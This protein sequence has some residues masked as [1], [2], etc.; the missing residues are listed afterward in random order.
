MQSFFYARLAKF[1]QHCAKENFASLRTA[2]AK[3]T[4]FTEHKPIETSLVFASQSYQTQYI[5]LK[6][7]GF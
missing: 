6:L 3:L 4:K 1:A 2:Y 5:S 7:Q